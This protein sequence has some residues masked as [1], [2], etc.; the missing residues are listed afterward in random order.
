MQGV[1]KLPVGG[2][3]SGAVHSNG[4]LRADDRRAGRVHR[5][6]AAAACARPAL[7][8]G[9]VTA[10]SYYDLVQARGRVRPRPRQA[11]P[12]SRSSSAPVLATLRRVWTS[13][14][15]VRYE[16]I[17]HWPAAERC[18]PR[19]PPRHRRSGGPAD[20]RACGPRALLRRPRSAN[21]HLCD[22]R[23]RSAR[24]EGPDPHQRRRRRE[25]RHSP[26]ATLMVI[27]DHINLLGSNP[28][29]GPN[30]ERVRRRDFPIMTNV[31]SPRLRRIADDAGAA[32]DSDLR[33]RRLRRLS[34]PELRDP[35]RS[36]LP[37]DDR[38]RRGR[39]V[40]GPRSDRRAAHGHGSARD[41]VHH[42]H[43]R[44]RAAPTAES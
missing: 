34:W 8:E 17:P 18:R 31:Y 41:F 20:R 35:G 15:S 42:E 9:T 38:R 10:P 19:G 14:V 37:A 5:A 29:I 44:R 16:K 40:D 7:R 25:Y 21:G 30:D 12:E 3:H 2:R 27:D 26:Q 28:L 43:G 6:L 1:V 22:P 39:D 23:A 11:V 36:S 13:A 4:A 24:R 32:L 33:A